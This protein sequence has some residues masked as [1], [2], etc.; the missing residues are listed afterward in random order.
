[1][2]SRTQPPNLTNTSGQGPDATV[3]P[4]LQRWNLGAAVFMF[5]WWTVNVGF[6]KT[7]WRDLTQ[8]EHFGHG[9]TVTLTAFGQRGNELSWKY[10]RWRSVT[11]FQRAQRWWTVGAGILLFG[12][13]IGIVALVLF[14]LIQAAIHS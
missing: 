14:A 8:S 11:T 10:R 1:M 5:L 7:A 13:P 2:P 6:N 3:P 12:P 4:Q 9:T